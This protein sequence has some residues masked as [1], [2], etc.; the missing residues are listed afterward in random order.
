M[1]KRHGEAGRK[2]VEEK[3]NNERVSQAWLD[4]YKDMLGE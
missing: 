1:R 3:F 2:R 4:I